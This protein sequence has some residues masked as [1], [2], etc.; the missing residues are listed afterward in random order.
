MNEMNLS[1][2]PLEAFRKINA[3]LVAALDDMHPDEVLALLET[4]KDHCELTIETAF[5]D[6]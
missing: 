1:G 5:E 2:K 3:I 4:V 6:E